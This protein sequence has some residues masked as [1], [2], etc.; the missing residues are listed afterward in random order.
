MRPIFRNRN[1]YYDIEFT[2][3][4][5]ISTVKRFGKLLIM[6]N[7]ALYRPMTIF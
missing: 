7:E 6:I 5:M 2:S 1:F 3:S 4:T